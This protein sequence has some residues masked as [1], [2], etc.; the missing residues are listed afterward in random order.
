MGSKGSRNSFVAAAF[1]FFEVT[2]RAEFGKAFP[3]WLLIL[4]FSASTNSRQE[5]CWHLNVGAPSIFS[6]QSL[7]PVGVV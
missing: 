2:V 7:S 4:K 6:Q 1:D 3:K 5:L